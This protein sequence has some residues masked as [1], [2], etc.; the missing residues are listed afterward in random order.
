MGSGG[1]APPFLTSAPDGGEW[2]ASRIGRFTY[3]ERVH[4][5]RWIGGWVGPTAGMDDVEKSKTSC[6]CRDSNSVRPI[7][8]SSLYL[9]SY[10]FVL[11]VINEGLL[12][13]SFPWKRQID[14]YCLF[15]LVWEVQ[16]ETLLYR[17]G[18][19]RKEQERGGVRGLSDDSAG[20]L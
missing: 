7:R 5:T 16:A 2:Q 3:G 4:G 20:N 18:N 14:I 1:I 17:A 8:S 12:C 9:L 11:T 13:I 15:F 10:L 6:P 19:V